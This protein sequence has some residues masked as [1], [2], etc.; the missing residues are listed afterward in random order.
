VAARGT[1]DASRA[2]KQDCG[3]AKV[4]C[5]HTPTSDGTGSLPGNLH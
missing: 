3:G 2:G 1:E 5:P 4:E